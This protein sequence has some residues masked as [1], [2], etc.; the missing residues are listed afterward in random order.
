MIAQKLKNNKIA[1]GNSAPRKDAIE[2]IYDLKTAEFLLLTKSAREWSESLNDRRDIV[3]TVYENEKSKVCVE[4]DRMVSR[5]K[6]YEEKLK[7]ERE[8]EEL[9]GL[10]AS[11]K[12]SKKPIKEEVKPKVD[13]PTVKVK[14]YKSNVEGTSKLLRLPSKQLIKIIRRKNVK[15]VVNRPDVVCIDNELREAFFDD[16]RKTAH[17]GK[18]KLYELL[19]TAVDKDIYEKWNKIIDDLYMQGAMNANN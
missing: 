9:I 8:V 4:F 11:K 1:I 3:F 17:F 15:D 5:R 16:V 10:V 6:R 2:V 18:K 14:F 7:Q 13:K 19:N 12:D